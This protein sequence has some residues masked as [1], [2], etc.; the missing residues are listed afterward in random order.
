MSTW[1]NQLFLLFWEHSFRFLRLHFTGQQVMKNGVFPAISVNQDD[2]VI[3]FQPSRVLRKE[4]YTPG[5]T[6]VR[7]QPLPKVSPR[8]LRMWK[9]ARRMAPGDAWKEWF[10]WAQTLASSHTEQSAKFLYLRDLVF[11]TSQKYF[12]GSDYLPILGN[13]YTT[14]LPLSPAN[15]LGALLSG[16][17]EILSPEFPPD[18]T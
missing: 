13:F 17:L 15:L 14:W 7:L 4:E 8:E 11:S 9:S 1:A 18:K 2:K 10:Q 5:L 12:W 16:W 3:S 6:A